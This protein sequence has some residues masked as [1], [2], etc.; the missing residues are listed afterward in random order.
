MH[1]NFGKKIMVTG[2]PKKIAWWLQ[3]R[4]EEYGRFPRG[5]FVE[6]ADWKRILPED[7][8]KE[9]IEAI[10]ADV[11]ISQFNY[12]IAHAMAQKRGSYIR[13]AYK[14]DI[15]VPGS[16]VPLTRISEVTIRLQVRK[17]HE[18]PDGKGDTIVRKLPFGE[19][20]PKYKGL[21]IRHSKKAKTKDKASEDYGK[22][23]DCAYLRYYAGKC[24]KIYRK[25]EKERLLSE[26]KEIFEY[27]SNRKE[28]YFIG[29]KEVDLDKISPES[30]EKAK[31]INKG[32]PS[33]IFQVDINNILALGKEW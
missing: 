22:I 26:G 13:L 14:T 17:A 2:S 29:N 20:D 9:E 23:M 30:A 21:I 33:D 7:P 25:G 5:A 19:W 16:T 10:I 32:K 1:V 11:S 8:T 31:K 4:W 12:V 18:D 27:T 3:A 24:K 28:T 6:E 15:T